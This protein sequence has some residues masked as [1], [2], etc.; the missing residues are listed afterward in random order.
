MGNCGGCESNFNAAG[1]LLSEIDTYECVTFSASSN[2]EAQ[3][4]TQINDEDI[5]N[6][7]EVIKLSKAWVSSFPSQ[8]D[9]EDVAEEQEPH[10]AATCIQ[11]SWNLSDKVTPCKRGLVSAVLDAYNNHHN[12]VLRPDDFWSA[13]M[14]QFGFY[15]TGNS[16][17]LRDRLVDFS[18][19]QKLEIQAAGTLFTADFGTI[20]NR[21]V[22]E[23]IVKWLRDP[24]LAEWLIPNFSTT[25]PKD[26][27]VCSV[28]LMATMQNFFDYKFTLKC[29]IP[30]VT[31]LGTPE[32]W[33]MLR[34]KIDR[35]VEFE[36]P[37]KD[38]INRWHSWL[39]D[40]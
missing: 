32:D 40:I 33:G 10:A 26:R 15:V 27:I 39:S 37:G 7:G 5:C 28:S 31:L 14:I 29:G 20:A 1:V 23:Q 22:D 21:M 8:E 12:L 13:I 19:K 2:Y 3:E 6:L 35:L 34:E 25:T 24:S 4:P 36:L 30:N 38:I 11:G 17:A 9:P 18:G 16:E